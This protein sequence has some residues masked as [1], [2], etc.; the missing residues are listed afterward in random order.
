M[1]HRLN[2]RRRSLIGAQIV[3]N[4]GFSTLDCLVKDISESGARLK[5][6]NTLAVPEK[7]SLSLSDGRRFE[8]TVQWRRADMVGVQFAA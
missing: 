1:D 5:V 6:E 3:S 2:H 7:F 4:N 8:S